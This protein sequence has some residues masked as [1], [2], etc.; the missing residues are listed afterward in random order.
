[1]AGDTDNPRVW[2]TADVYVAPLATAAP[3]TVAGALNAAWDPLGLLSEDGLT[4]TRNQDRT[5]H[6]AWGGILVR[7]TRARMSR[8]FQVTALEDNQTV[9]EL[10]NPG[11]TV[12]TAG[13]ETTRTILTPTPDPRMF[14]FELV[15]G[16]ITKRIVIPRGEVSE[17]GDTVYSEGGIAMFPLTI[18]V[19]PTTFLSVDNTWYLE[20]TDDPA[21]DET[22]S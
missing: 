4:E 15:D 9:Y 22:F 12:N 19:Y 17:V 20:I 18:T 10:V 3:T 13:G 14:L 5:D 21:A 2:L 16:D 11:S 8:T 1:M 7:S 6:Y